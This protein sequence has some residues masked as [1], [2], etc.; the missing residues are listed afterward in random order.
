MNAIEF[1]TDV[2]YGKESLPS[3]FYK[4]IKVGKMEK[5]NR[6]EIYNG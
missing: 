4:P 1:E 2:Q 5:F 3:L 6:E